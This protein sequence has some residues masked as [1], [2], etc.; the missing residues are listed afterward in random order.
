MY[1]LLG[2]SL[3]STLHSAQGL[4]SENAVIV[5]E[6]ILYLSRKSTIQGYFK[7][8]SIPYALLVYVKKSVITSLEI[9]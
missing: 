4:S 6:D 1:K 5:T 7:Q 3:A 2:L 8:L 9:C